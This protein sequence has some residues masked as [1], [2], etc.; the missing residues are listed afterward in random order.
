M[1]RLASARILPVV[2]LALVALAILKAANLWIGFAGA[3]AAED[4]TEGKSVAEA[5]AAAPPA[6][7][8]PTAQPSE[9][10]RRIL[11]QL[12]ERRATL[13]AREVAI[14]TREQ[15]LEV[16][17]QRL[18]KRFTELAAKEA[19]MAAALGEHEKQEAAEF[20]ELSNTYERMKPKDA[21]RIFEVLEDDI[22][23]PV[24]AGMRTQALSGVLA[25]MDPGKAK[26][27]TRLLAA[28]GKGESPPATAPQ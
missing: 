5:T 24:A 28:H 9:T 6:A 26:A 7:I 20:E 4:P 23:V 17:E 11:E 21:A 16:A 15:L 14:A 25:E 22:L 3:S 8:A 27:L 18:E 10:E 12:A 13:D 19:E 2:I 1:T